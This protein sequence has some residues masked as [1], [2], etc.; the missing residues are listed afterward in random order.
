MASKCVIYSP[1]E[2]NPICYSS[3]PCSSSSHCS[4]AGMVLADIGSLSLSPNYGVI[5]PASS[6][7][8]LEIERSSWVF[9]FTGSHQSGDVVLEGKGSDCSDAFGENNDTANRNANSID[10]NPNNENMNSGKETDSG[11]SKLCARGHWRPAEDT[12]LKELVALYG[13][14]NWNLI[15]EKLEGRSGKRTRNAFIFFPCFRF[16]LLLTLLLC[17][18]CIKV[19][20]AD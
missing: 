17:G 16:F 20:A 2:N 3:S 13:P 14:Q 6:S 9:P 11:Q 5:P 4:S 7:H 1:S 19:K 8:E 18:I 12:K 10:E 15:A